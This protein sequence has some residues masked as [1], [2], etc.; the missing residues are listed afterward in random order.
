M[1]PTASRSSQKAKN[2]V[3]A[4][5]TLWSIIS[6]IVIVVWATSPDL[7]SS[8]RCRAELQDVTE[9]LEGAKVV[10]NKNK[11][12]LEEQVVAGREEQDRQR[13]EIVL[14]LGHLNATN[15]T[16]EECWQE[17]VSDGHDTSS[18]S[19][20]STQTLTESHDSF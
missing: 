3:I 9:K 10:W 6:L 12:A 20:S 1:D 17:K 19:V 2:V 8:S 4:L 13:A 15:H 14:L 11:V 5:L 7:K 16:L 18:F